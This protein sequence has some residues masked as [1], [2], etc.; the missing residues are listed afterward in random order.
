MRARAAALDAAAAPAFVLIWS[1]GFLVARLLR[2]EVD[3]NLFL[4]ARFGMTALLFVPVALAADVA[5]P[6]G[7]DALRHLAA[8]VL[9]Q[10]IYL[11]AGYWAVAHGL[12]AAVMALL[13]SLQPLL[14]ALLARAVLGE[15][16]VRRTWAGLLIGLAGVVLVIAPRL[17]NG[18]LLASGSGVGSALV[19]AVA[20]LG[21][22][23]LTAGA[24]VQK[25]SIAAADLRSASAIQN[26]GAAVTCALLAWALG[27]H[28]WGGGVQSLAVLVWSGV[29]LSGVATTLLVWMLRRGEAA[30]VSAVLLLVP[31]LVAVETFLLFGDGLTAL[32]IAGFV[33]AIGGVWLARS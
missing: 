26:L 28:R 25:T 16:V 5:W 18:G 22:F 12:P 23:S 14:V 10:G 4:A 7:T 30:R 19:L 3:P 2:G 8:G 6:R 9:I 31:P 1:T 21:I 17:A 20:V 13:G 33:V 24:V 29:A 11:G 32:Q 27:E 15:R